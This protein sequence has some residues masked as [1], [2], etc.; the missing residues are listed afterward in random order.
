LNGDVHDSAA[1]QAVIPTEILIEAEAEKAVLIFVHEPLGADANFG[2]NA[3]AAERADG[4]AIP[5]DQ[6][7]RAFVLRR[8]APSADDAA[9]GDDFAELYSADDLGEEIYH[10]KRFEMASSAIA[11]IIARQGQEIAIFSAKIGEETISK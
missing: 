3:S 1:D 8:A 7:R 11:I 9:Q 10:N 6:H 4:I 5:Q 2:F